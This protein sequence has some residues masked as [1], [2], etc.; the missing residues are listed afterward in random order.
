MSSS[1]GHLTS[2][3]AS[4]RCPHG[5]VARPKPLVIVPEEI[6]CRVAVMLPGERRRKLLMG[7]D[8]VDLETGGKG[9]GGRF[10]QTVSQYA[11]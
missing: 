10:A 9:S 2:V 5:S 4:R 6:A 1:E 3:S 11:E 7:D 8:L